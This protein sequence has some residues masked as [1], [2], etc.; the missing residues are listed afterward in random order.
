MFY[1]AIA[2]ISGC[3]CL[4]AHILGKRK[5]LLGLV[6]KCWDS[7]SD[8]LVDKQKSSRIS[9]QKSKLATFLVLFGFESVK[10]KPG[11]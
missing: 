3:A 1:K 8:R 9:Q 5:T 7:A 2:H 4:I 10:N 6:E 11:T